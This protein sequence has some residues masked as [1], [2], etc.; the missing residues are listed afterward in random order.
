M[1]ALLIKINDKVVCCE[2]LSDITTKQFLEYQKEVKK[3]WNSKDA[4]I[5]KLQNE[6]AIAQ[7][8]LVSISKR[9]DNLQHQ[10]NVIT[11]VEEESEETE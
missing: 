6:L 5:K 7:A 2:Q 10:I 8:D 3:N 11:G 1:K 9:C 4:E